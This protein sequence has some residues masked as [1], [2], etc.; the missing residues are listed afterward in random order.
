MK[1]VIDDKIPFIQGV[2]EEKA[3]VIYLPGSEISAL[4]LVDADGLII[5]TRTKCKEQ[6]LQGSS[7]KFI[8]TATIGFDHIDTEYCR[9]AGIK[10]TNA[11]G[12]NADSVNQYMVSALT[13]WADVKKTCLE[14]KT[15]GILGVGNVGSRVATSAETLGLKVMLN[16]PPRAR[17]EGTEG[18]VEID[19][20][21]KEA[22]IISLHV[23]LNMS[24]PD[25]TYHLVDSAFLKK[26]KNPDL[27]INTCRGEVT[28]TETVNKALKEGLIG[29]CIIDCWENEPEINTH[30]LNNCLIG[31]PHIAGYSRDGKANGTAQCVQAI[32]KYFD[33]EFKNWY[34]EKIDPPG[35]SHIFLDGNGMNQEQVIHAA[36][37]STYA[38]SHDDQALK[39]CTKNFE[40]LRGDYPVRREFPA[41]TLTCSNIDTITK[42]KLQQLGFNL[43]K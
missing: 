39:S 5:R 32:S 8:A 31:T 3:D 42:N 24:G 33:L 11:P 25:K 40:K 22:D 13:H 36:V 18:F 4:D 1:F 23:P 17:E 7:V 29:D 43:T 41:F 28:H 27:L 26:W 12:C 9:E 20:I 35:I 21:L 34:P 6:L 38:V 37:Q 2:L 19:Q 30:L 15:I 14:G 10:W 16:D